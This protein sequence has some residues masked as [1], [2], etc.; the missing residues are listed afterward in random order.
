MSYIIGWGMLSPTRRYPDH[1][2]AFSTIKVASFFVSIYPSE[3]FVLVVDGGRESRSHGQRPLYKPDIGAA[4]S[5]A[6]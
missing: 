1:A 2:P 4:S 3:P 6:L 5:F